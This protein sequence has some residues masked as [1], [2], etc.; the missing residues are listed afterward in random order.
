MR[1]KIC[2]FRMRN[3]KCNF[4]MRN[5]NCNKLYWRMYIECEII[6]L[7]D[8]TL[9]LKEKMRIFNHWRTSL[10]FHLTFN[11]FIFVIF[12]ISCITLWLSFNNKYHNKSKRKSLQDQLSLRNNLVKQFQSRKSLEKHQ[13]NERKS[14]KNTKRNESMKRQILTMN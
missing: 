6:L 10:I 9:S 4:R 14:S 13:S 3:E 7:C 8:W 5:E 12:I 11:W 2:N 1:N